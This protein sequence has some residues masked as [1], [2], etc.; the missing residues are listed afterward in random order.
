LRCSRG[1]KYYDDRNKNDSDESPSKLSIIEEEASE[2][3]NEY[4]IGIIIVQYILAILY[5]VSYVFKFELYPN[6]D[7]LNQ[8]TSSKVKYSPL[9]WVSWLT[10]IIFFAILM[11]Y[12]KKNRRLI[13]DSSSLESKIMNI[14][15]NTKLGMWSPK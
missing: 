15:F 7:K 9:N 12:E 4:F 11:Q 10:F 8:I 5:L 2:L 14:F 6:N 3:Y 13:Y 1:R